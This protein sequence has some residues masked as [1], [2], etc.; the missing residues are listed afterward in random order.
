ME[1]VIIS[2]IWCLRLFGY[3]LVSIVRKKTQNAQNWMSDF[4]LYTQ[5]SIFFTR[6]FCRG[7]SPKDRLRCLEKPGCHFLIIIIIIYKDLDHHKHHQD[8]GYHDNHGNYNHH[9]DHKHH[10]N[11]NH[12]KHHD[13]LDNQR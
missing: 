12:H 3:R 5:F 10:D 1:M 6:W 11:H 8:H 7:L 13:H 9:K 4:D 2:G